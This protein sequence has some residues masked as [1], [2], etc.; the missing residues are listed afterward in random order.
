MSYFPFRRSLL[1]LGLS[2]AFLPGVIAAKCGEI[3]GKGDIN[4]VGSAFPALQHIAKEM[5]SCNRAG[6]KIAFKMTP[7]ARQETERAFASDGKSP[8]DAAVISMGTFGGLLSKGQLQP[9]TDLVGKYQ[10]KYKIEEK[11]LVRI[12]GEVMAIAFMQ[13]AQNLFYRKDIFDLVL[14]LVFAH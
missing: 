10:A 11:M 8:F 6:L 7:E 4:I 13:N 2:L 14:R 3:T 9:M 1:V 12:N 5:E